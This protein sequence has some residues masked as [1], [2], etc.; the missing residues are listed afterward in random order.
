MKIIMN[1]L[2]MKQLYNALQ[3]LIYTYSLYCRIH[4][5]S[6]IF[7]ETASYEKTLTSM[8]SYRSHGK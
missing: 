3:G 5:N 1:L 6:I 4:I 7:S 2:N 8:R